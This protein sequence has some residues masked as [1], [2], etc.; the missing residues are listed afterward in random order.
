MAPE[1]CQGVRKVKTV[2]TYQSGPA[3]AADIGCQLAAQK[4][5]GVADSGA[6]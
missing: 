2:H 5:N 3:P 6:T 4:H 1:W